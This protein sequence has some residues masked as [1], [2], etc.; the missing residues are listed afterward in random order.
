MYSIAGIYQSADRKMPLHGDQDILLPLPGTLLS[1][2]PTRPDQTGHAVRRPKDAVALSE[3]CPEAQ[4]G[5][6]EEKAVLA[7]SLLLECRAVG[8]MELNTVL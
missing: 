8:K 3:G 5:N 7:G 2:R 4:L 1:T 6:V